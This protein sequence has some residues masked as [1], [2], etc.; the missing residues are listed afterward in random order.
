MLKYSAAGNSTFLLI[1]IQ[2]AKVANKENDNSDEDDGDEELNSESEVMN[3]YNFIRFFIQT[4]IQPTL[5]NKLR[6]LQYC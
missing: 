4:C 1:L 6:L 5:M 3:I 2:N